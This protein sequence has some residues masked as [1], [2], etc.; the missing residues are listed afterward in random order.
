MIRFPEKAK[1]TYDDLLEIIRLLR[2]PEGCPWDKAQTHESI[3]RGL[4]EEA[5]EAAESIDNDDPVGM[6]EELGDLMMQVVFHADIEKDA[7]RFTME[8]VCDGVVRKLLFRHPHVFA[9]AD[10]KNDT[11]AEVLLNWEELKKKEKGFATTG[12]AMEAVAKSLPGLWRAEKIQKKAASAGFDWPEVSGA[13]NKLREEVQEL[14]TAIENKSNMAEELGDLLFA[15]V[16][17]GRFLEID[18]EKALHDACDKFN[19][20]FRAMEQKA[21]KAEKDFKELT[22]D[23]KLSLWENVKVQ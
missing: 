10:T 14:E 13:M 19:A 1:Y 18:P 6:Q 22:L 11:P 23:E 17:V 4:L 8:E 15:A 5:Y 3:R 20:R 7:G 9:A 21:A 12:E 2:S 16:K